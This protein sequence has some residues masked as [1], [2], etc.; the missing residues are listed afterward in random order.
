MRE[1]LEQVTLGCMRCGNCNAVCPI[2]REIGEEA[3]SPRGRVRLI[4][5]VSSGEVE[6]SARYRDIIGWCLNCRACADECPSG[7]EPNTAVLDARQHVVLEKGLSAAKRAIFRGAMRGRRIFPASAKLMGLLQRISFIGKQG[8]PLRLAFPLAGL[9]R[10]KAIPYFALKTFLDRMPEVMP[11]ENRKRRVAYFAGCAANLM[12]P[13]VGEAVVGLLN[14][15]GVEVVIPHRQ[16]CCGTPIFNSGDFEGGAYF[17]RRNLSAFGRLDVDAIITSCGS[18]G[19]AI[20]HEWKDLLGMDVPDDLTSK[21]Y[22]ITEF[23]V[24]CLGIMEVGVPQSE[25]R[26]PKSEITYHDSCHLARGMGVRKQPRQLLASVPGT[27]LMEMAEADTCCGAGG[28]FSIYHPDLSRRIGDR[29]AANV[30]ATKADIVATGCLSCT[31]QLSEMLARA[32]SSQKVTHTA[33]V[34]WDAVRDG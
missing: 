33:C 23:L 19:L 6:L 9:P 22:D 10:D 18:C 21:V 2:F 14:H 5:G 27:E 1:K 28:T 17:A 8:N 34:L 20:K 13:E 31:M 16:M 24:D 25:I 4:R 12:F 26:N 7:I 32:G 11:V 29:K 30:A 15:Y 3:A